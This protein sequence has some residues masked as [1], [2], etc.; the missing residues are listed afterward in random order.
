MRD[1]GK[2]R[3]CGRMWEN[4]CWEIVIN[5]VHNGKIEKKNSTSTK[6]IAILNFVFVS[7]SRQL[8]R[9]GDNTI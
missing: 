3:W 8:Y 9:N 2:H 5:K 1:K 7:L 4:K 6:L